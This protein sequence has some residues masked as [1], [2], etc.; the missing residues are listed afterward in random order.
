MLT[1]ENTQLSEMFNYVTNWTA[2]K[3]VS[4]YLG[5][6][7]ANATPEQAN[8]ETY[9]KLWVNS[10]CQQAET[11]RFGWAYWAFSSTGTISESFGIL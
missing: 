2:S 6:F 8:F 11:Q 10:V 3:N 4:V 9:R 1:F 5:E 7:G